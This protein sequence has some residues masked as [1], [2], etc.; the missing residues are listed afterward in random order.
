MNNRKNFM[1]HSNYGRDN[2]S[3]PSAAD[4]HLQK[5]N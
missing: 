4:G 2:I 1:Q 5:K 3:D